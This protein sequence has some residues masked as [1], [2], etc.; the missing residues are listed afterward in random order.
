M[1]TEKD[2]RRHEDTGRRNMLKMNVFTFLKLRGEKLTRV[3]MIR[4]ATG[5]NLHSIHNHIGKWAGWGYLCVHIGMDGRRYYTLTA[6]AIE[7]VK[8]MTTK[9][10]SAARY[11]GMERQ[12]LR[13]ARTVYYWIDE[14]RGIVAGL[15]APFDSAECVKVCTIPE[16]GRP[17][18][19]RFFD[20][21]HLT[22]KVDSAN[23]AVERMRTLYDKAPDG[24]VDEMV[25]RGWIRYADAERTERLRAEG[26]ERERQVQERI[27]QI[28]AE[29]HAR[30]QAAGGLHFAA[31]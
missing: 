1:K 30:I 8:Y 17:F 4:D 21:A 3:K 7:Y 20:D 5:E 31:R 24:A 15:V 29:T 12:I 2:S 25:R 19:P 6:H 23:N 14:K 26:L 27:K 11:A 16:S 18:T 22:I 10:R 13:T 28:A 9:S